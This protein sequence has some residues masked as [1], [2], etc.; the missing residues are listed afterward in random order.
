LRFL[1]SLSL[2]SSV[3]LFLLSPLLQLCCPLIEG[4]R[5]LTLSI[6]PYFSDLVLPVCN[7][8]PVTMLVSYSPPPPIA[9][10]SLVK[11]VFGS[12]ITSLSPQVNYP[13]PNHL[14]FLS[15]SVH[16]FISQGKEVRD[17]ANF[18]KLQVCN[19]E[20][21]RARGREGGRNKGRSSPKWGRETF[22][23]ISSDPP[24]LIITFNSR[25]AIS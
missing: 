3:F 19:G 1:C 14:V 12:N 25:H 23:M 13:P 11:N 20:G 7:L 5:T 4:L 16:L 18:Q 17:G 6:S 10:P 22:F 21:R 9:L 24:L 2:P 15:L 8:S